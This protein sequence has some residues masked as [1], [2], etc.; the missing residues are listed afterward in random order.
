MEAVTEERHRDHWGSEFEMG[1]DRRNQGI[2]ARQQ[3]QRGDRRRY[4]K[5]PAMQRSGN[6]MPLLLETARNQAHGRRALPICPRL[7]LVH[8][9]G[10]PIIV[11]PART[12]SPT[13]T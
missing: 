2:E 11:S 9:G 8:A 5:Y 3:S 6:L 1:M 7:L 10:S 13:R 4:Y 12:R